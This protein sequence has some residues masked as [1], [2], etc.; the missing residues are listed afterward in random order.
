MIGLEKHN[1]I[2]RALL[3]YYHLR[4]AMI[5]TFIF[6]F[7]IATITY[8]LAKDLTII[9]NPYEKFNCYFSLVQNICLVVYMK[10]SFDLFIVDFTIASPTMSSPTTTGF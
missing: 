3:I 9:S 4:K 8:L 2:Q 1:Q 6:A 7:L 10:L 5:F